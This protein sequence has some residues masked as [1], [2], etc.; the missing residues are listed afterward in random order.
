MFQ[1]S[2][3]K[4]NH[5]ESEI[6]HY[7]DSNKKD[8]ILSQCNKFY[9]NVH[10]KE[11][12]FI[13]NLKW[14]FIFF[15]KFRILRR[16]FRL[17]K[18]NVVLNSKKNG[19]IIIYQKYIYFYCLKK[20]TFNIVSE[21][22][23]HRNVLHNSIAV[24]KNGIFFG[25]YGPNR[26]KTKVPVWASFNDGRNWKIIYNFPSRSIKHIHGIY[27]DPFENNL[28]ITTGDSNGECY[29]FKV[30]NKKFS[31]IIQYGDGTQKWRAVS[32]LFKKNYI[33]WG[34]DSPLQASNLQIF[35]KKTKKLK[36]GCSFP[37]PVWY[38]KTFSD[39]S[40]ILQTS[41]EIGDGVKSNYSSLFYSKD[42]IS[43]SEICKF[44]KD[45]FPKK[46]FKF[47]VIAFSEGIQT[48][49]DFL[50]SAEGL[51]K[52]DGKVFSGNISLK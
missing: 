40:A 52:I 5:L 17:D 36:K 28:W 50:F 32:L 2:L 34:M 48:S 26:Y 33:I 6:A 15:A 14:Y 3:K 18:S 7:Y 21:L 49:K 13:I 24:T 43:W 51:K 45:I 27:N 37:G 4:N 29:L 19:A 41:V 22:K 35:N 23:N 39:K 12:F 46:L 9:L 20:K 30:P 47:G 11:Y 42:L 16:L 44:K 10:N 38:S 8:V 25:E 1:F 31:N